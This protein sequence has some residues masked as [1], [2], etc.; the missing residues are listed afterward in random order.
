M[1]KKVIAWSVFL[2]CVLFLSL[3]ATPYSRTADELLI[4]IRLTLVIVISVLVVRERWKRPRESRPDST[5]A[6]SAFL[7]RV[8]TWYHGE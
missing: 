4:T 6:D 3:A 2:A 5:D 1:R 8:R 7:R